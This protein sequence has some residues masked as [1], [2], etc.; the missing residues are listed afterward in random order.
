MCV[1]IFKIFCCTCARNSFFN[2]IPAN[3]CF[4]LFII[5]IK[6]ITHED[7]RMTLITDYVLGCFFLTNSYHE[8]KVHISR[9]LS[10][11]YGYIL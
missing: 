4:K 1:F 10:H 8:L 3:V 5:V 11:N 2:I 9:K 7:E 6:Y